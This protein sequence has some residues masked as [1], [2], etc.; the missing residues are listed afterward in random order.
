MKVDGH[1]ADLDDVNTSQ[2]MKPLLESFVSVTTSPAGSY[3]MK[4]QIENDAHL[5]PF[6]ETFYKNKRYDQE[7]QT[8]E[9]AMDYNHRR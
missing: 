3:K 8:N 2:V 9:V 1:N 4:S 5:I 6:D 7:M